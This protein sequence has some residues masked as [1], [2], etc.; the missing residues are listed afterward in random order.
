MVFGGENADSY[1]DEGVTASMKGDLQ[2]AIKFFEQAIKM[3]RSHYSAYHHLGKCYL[4]MG[5]AQKASEYFHFVIKSR[6]NLI[7]PRLDLGFALLD[8][9][10][11]DRAQTIFEEI[12]RLKPDN[13]RASL[14][15]AH[16]AFQR[17]NWEVAMLLAQ[18]AIS[19]GGSNFGTYFLLGRAA[20]FSNRPDISAD[21]MQRADSLIEKHIE[22]NPSQPE[23][24]Y[25]RGEVQFAQQAF[26]KAAD[27]FDRAA[28]CAQPGR[29]YGAYD[30]HFTLTD[31]LIKQGLCLQRMGRADAA[32]DIGKRILEADPENAL[33]KKLME[34]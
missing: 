18:T 29:Q 28:Q 12:S 31:I 27:F 33:A 25:L 16:C 17:A 14:G 23:G 9:G 4:R 21:A 5:Q 22:A 24:Y 30:A 26:D 32:R 15:M 34:G 1:Y 8:L 20:I 6:P 2:E 11:P 3:D 13:A 10:M 7:P 19:Q